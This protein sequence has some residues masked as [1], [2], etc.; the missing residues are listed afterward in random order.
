[1]DA[2]FA[3]LLGCFVL[4]GFA[5]LL[6]QTV[7]TRELSFVFGT[8]E[9][10]VAAV[11]AAYMGGLGLGA[12]AAAR[13]APR[14]RRPIRAYGW[15]ELAI[16]ALA[17]LVPAGIHAV[18]AIYA[19]LLGG[20]SELPQAGA[21]STLLQ[22]A[23]AAAVLVPPTALMGA[24]LPLLSGWAVRVDRQLG[25][26]VG[27]L[28]AV[29]TVGAI[30][31]TVCAT[32]WLIPELGLRQTA[33]VGAALNVAVF[34]LAVLLA[35]GA[36]ATALAPDPA[37][38]VAP[39]DR[40]PWI[41]PAIALSGS[42]SFAHEVLWTRLLGHVLG[43]SLQA[44]AS[45]L[46]SFLLGI[47]LGSAAAARIAT[48]RERA[49][50]GF[51]IAQLGIALLSYVVYAQSDALPGFAA[52]LRIG[53]EGSLAS[54][55]LAAATLLPITICIGAT[56][57]FAVRILG[58]GAEH[59]ARAT[60]RVYTWNTFGAIAGALG[61]SFVLLPAFGFAGTVA[62]GAAT[63]LALAAASALANAPRRIA[64]AALAGALG[65]GLA[66]RPPSAPWALLR[67][68]PLQEG[69]YFGDIVFTAV[70]RSSTVVLLDQLLSWR[71]NSN[72]LP[73]ASIERA[74]VLPLPGS[75]QYWLGFLPSL[76][77][78]ELRD[79][80]VIGLGGGTGV[81]SV[82]ASV[83]AI[84]VI[85]LEPEVVAA[86]RLIASERARDP[87]ADPRVR[88]H[89]GD[90]RG[91]LSLTTKRYGA[92]VSQPS[93]PWTSGASHLYTREFFAQVREHLA[94][95][96]VFVQWIA[97][98][99]LDEA[100]L[101]SLAATL[102][103]AFG[104]VEIFSPSGA[105]ILFAAS[106]EPLT[107]LA[108]PERALRATPE[109]YARF[110]VH[111][112]ED[113]ANAWLVDEAG[114][115]ALAQGAPLIT[116]DDNL[117]A[118]RSARLGR[119]A[120]DVASARELFAA[121][122]PLRA[123]PPELDRDALMRTLARQEDTSRARRLATPEAGAPRERELGWI[124]LGDG[125]RRGAARH[126][127]RAL[128]LAPGDR[129]AQI[130]L[131]ASRQPD[132]RNGPVPEIDERQLDA[133]TAAVLA[134]WRAAPGSLAAALAPHDEALAQLAPGDALFRDAARLRAQWRLEE[135]GPQRSAEA[136]AITER[137]QSA[138]ASPDD[139]LLHARAALEAGATT[140]AWASLER[141]ASLAPRGERGRDVARRALALA[142]RLP[143]ERAA[144]L[145][146]RL[147]RRTGGLPAGAGDPLFTS[148]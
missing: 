7:W 124:D 52:Q 82:P 27:A 144:G 37:H 40:A 61:A 30:G 122:E 125:K 112:I 98:P 63:S 110:G 99:F 116:D 77:R 101:R 50:V 69:G 64:I 33:W 17:L 6:Y 36:P 115:R 60:A 12:A 104:H 85:E 20:A 9:L 19:V 41:L 86:N 10:A 105:A 108:G 92:I 74:G 51:A 127:A 72:G 123:G 91:A 129:A 107:G 81:E 134:G 148:R 139:A 3:L 76:V 2:R 1:M 78:P 56:F 43:A 70:G 145:R 140:A 130:G 132:L 94:P 113:V 15:I 21:A 102:V 34:A 109:D 88:V 54:A 100:L 14:L 103:D 8:S 57:P 11:L 95:D 121:G 24:T 135:G 131:V 22:L 126:F 146:V 47:A 128:E 18:A 29:N 136:L 13:L 143:E 80:L 31:G 28:Y 62:I 66:W 58:T 55:A 73:E 111:R 68:S 5:A 35:R 120:L 16:A 138:A 114:V 46:A 67:R 106:P 118:S 65:V 53:R 142:E 97:L 23:G 96:G 49:R 45:M 25:S 44:F 39:A 90:A 93:H 84:D 42:V 48:T 137:L 89:I 141:V 26:R 87:L 83:A 59:A 117:L 38:R 79:L 71:L 75:I 147:E 133:P 119:G 32:F 4:S